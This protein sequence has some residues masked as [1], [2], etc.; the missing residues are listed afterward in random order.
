MRPLTVG[1]VVRCT[2]DILGNEAVSKGVVY[3]IY[4]IGEGAGVSVI[5]ENGEYD[6]FSPTEQVQ[7]LERIRHS[8]DL[9][10]YQFKNVITVYEDYVNG[11]FDSAFE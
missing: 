2:V 4:N 7:L 10:G 5:F 8:P 3:E 9:A 11:V 6:G 1:D